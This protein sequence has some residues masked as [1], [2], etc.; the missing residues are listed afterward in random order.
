M[1]KQPNTLDEKI[2]MFMSRKARQYP[3]LG[4][5]IGSGK[6]IRVRLTERF[7][8]IRDRFNPM[9]PFLLE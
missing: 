2:D 7:S 3:D 5:K 9:G 4:L 1:N 6:N 8:S